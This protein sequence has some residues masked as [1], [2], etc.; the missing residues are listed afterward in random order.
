MLLHCALNILE[1]G[2]TIVIHNLLNTILGN[3]NIAGVSLIQKDVF[4]LPK[5]VHIFQY[6]SISQ[7]N[8]A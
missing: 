5:V 6:L 8:R 3:R 1:N 4:K 2:A 7:I